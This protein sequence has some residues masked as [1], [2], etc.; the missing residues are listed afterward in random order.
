MTKVGRQ[1]I[2]RTAFFSIGSSG[3]YPPCSILIVERYLVFED[4]AIL[5]I[6]PLW[7]WTT[8]SCEDGKSDAFRNVRSIVRREDRICRR[9]LNCLE[10][11]FIGHLLVA[12]A[13]DLNTLNGLLSSWSRYVT[14]REGVVGDVS[15]VVH[16]EVPAINLV[17]AK[18]L[19]AIGYNWS[20][21]IMV[22]YWFGISDGCNTL[23][24]L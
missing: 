19:H 20:S 13:I 22:L 4:L 11:R 23:I 2:G 12:D 1:I 17:D 16:I 14:V 15:E 24:G 5:V 10:V 18:S 7:V 6:C 21:P 3:A 8:T 9:N